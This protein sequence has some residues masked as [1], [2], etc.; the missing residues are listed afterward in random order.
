MKK[1]IVNKETC[2]SCGACVAIDDKHFTF[3]DNGISKV[4]SN[5]NLEDSNLINAIE[6]CPVAAIEIIDSKCNCGDECECDDDCNCTNDEE[7]CC[8]CSHCDGCK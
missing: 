1:I 2:I 3:D 7:D 4:I 8:D 6:S 5:D